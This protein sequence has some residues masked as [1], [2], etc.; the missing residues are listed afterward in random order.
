MGHRHA[1]HRPT[2]LLRAAN[3]FIALLAC[4]LASGVGAA[5]PPVL[6]LDDPF[7]STIW[8]VG[9]ERQGRTLVAGLSTGSLAVWNL[10]ALVKSR[11]LHL[12]IRDEEVRGAADKATDHEW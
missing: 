12:P 7:V 4:L 6:R 10:D 1:P 8:R 9:L 2:R 11:L 5:Q 3:T